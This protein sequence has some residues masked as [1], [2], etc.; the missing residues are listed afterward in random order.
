MNSSHSIYRYICFIYSRARSL[1]LTGNIDFGLNIDRT[2]QI[3]VSSRMLSGR[4]LQEISGSIA[5]KPHLHL[6][7][8][9]PSIP[10]AAFRSSTR[11][12]E[13]A[14]QLPHTTKPGSEVGI[15]RSHRQRRSQK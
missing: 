10:P 4:P 7:E 8:S 1:E 3:V 13:V 9:S 2:P 14:E 15:Q 11:P 6:P 12:P 5:E